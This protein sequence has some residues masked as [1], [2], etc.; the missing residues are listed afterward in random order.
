MVASARKRK[1]YRRSKNSD[2]LRSVQ[3]AW[4]RLPHGKID[5]RHDVRQLRLPQHVSLALRRR[6]GKRIRPWLICSADRGT[7]EG[8]TCSDRARLAACRRSHGSFQSQ[9]PPSWRAWRRTSEQL[10]VELTPDDLRDIDSAAS[11][12]TVQGARYPE[13]L[14]RMTYRYS[15]PVIKET[16]H[17][18]SM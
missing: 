15:C 12:I 17:A 11:K 13:E 4:Q 18:Q 14:E 2:R 16:F 8:D 1:C 6:L 10:P 7:E 3:S 9:A 5:R